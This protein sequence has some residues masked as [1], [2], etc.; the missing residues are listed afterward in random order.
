[1]L[2]PGAGDV[3]AL[4]H[5]GHFVDRAA[6]NSHAHLKFADDSFSASADLQRALRRRFRTVRKTSAMPSPVGNRNSL[7]SASAMRNCSVPRTISFSCL[8]RSLCSLIEQLRVTDDVD[9]QDVP[10]LE[11]SPSEEGS[12]GMGFPSLSSVWHYSNPIF[13]K[14]AWKRGSLRTLS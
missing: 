10:D 9:E 14:I 2:M 5:I 4:V 7:P 3:G 13:F 1:M 8:Q 11:L 6:V 12:V